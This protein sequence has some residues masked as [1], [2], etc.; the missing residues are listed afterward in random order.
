MKR[1]SLRD[2]IVGDNIPVKLDG[3]IHNRGKLPNDEINI[4]D[5]C[6]AGFLGVSQGDI[7]NALCN[8]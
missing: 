6:G 2:R 7:Q 1:C 3:I 5:S 4:G 8:R